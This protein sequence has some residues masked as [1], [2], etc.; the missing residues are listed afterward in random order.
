MTTDGILVVLSEI[1]LLHSPCVQ[2][3]LVSYCSQFRKQRN[4]I[5][6]TFCPLAAPCLYC[7]KVDGKE[8]SYPVFFS[9][10]GLQAETW[11]SL[12]VAKLRE[13]EGTVRFLF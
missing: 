2:T 5:L 12:N 7:V 3:V 11:F 10:E 4:V 6:K 13:V 9:E 8:G 1:R